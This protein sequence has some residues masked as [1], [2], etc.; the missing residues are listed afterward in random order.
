MED[1]GNGLMPGRRSDDA[2]EAQ[3]EA[4]RAPDVAE[5]KSRDAAGEVEH[6]AEEEALRDPGMPSAAQIA[7]TI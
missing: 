2:V 1:D 4:P 3:E 7:R 5:D 6:D